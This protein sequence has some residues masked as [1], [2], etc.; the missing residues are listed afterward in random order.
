MIREFAN[1]DGRTADV[2]TNAQLVRETLT[3]ADPPVRFVIAEADGVAAGFASFYGTYSTASARRRLW[4]EDLYVREPWQRRG[5]GRAL[6][7]HVAGVAIASECTAIDWSVGERTKTHWP[8]THRW[9][10]R[11]ENGPASAA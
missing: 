3:A 4:L 8:S 5:V 1:L 7:R 6:M 2:T 9:G 10:R 11:C